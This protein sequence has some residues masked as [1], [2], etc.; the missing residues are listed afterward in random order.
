[1]SKQNIQAAYAEAREIQVGLEKQATDALSTVKSGVRLSAT[2]RVGLESKF[3]KWAST[4]ARILCG[5]PQLAELT[6]K[7]LAALIKNDDGETGFDPSIISKRLAVGPRHY[8]GDIL[9]TFGYA[10]DTLITGTDIVKIVRRNIR[11]E[12][13]K[14]D[15]VVFRAAGVEI[16]GT[17]YFYRQRAT[18]PTGQ[19]WND[20]SIRISGHDTPLKVILKVR[21]IGINEFVS[22]DEAAQRVASPDDVAR[23]AKLNRAPQTSRHLK[24]LK[25]ANT[26]SQRDAAQAAP[27][28]DTTL[29]SAPIFVWSSDGLSMTAQP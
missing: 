18:T 21:N 26:T 4:L 16:N 11:T 24:K 14:D 3:P 13:L 25:T 9:R 2:I 12:T 5:S 28:D 1:M 17:N 6:N 7:Q 8:A 27:S 22:R 29:K 19:P 10:T 23:R 20:L 15:G